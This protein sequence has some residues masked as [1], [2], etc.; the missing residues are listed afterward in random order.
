MVENVSRQDLVR[1]V[2][3][4]TNLFERLVIIKQLLNESRK[5]GHNR[6][7][8]VIEPLWRVKNEG[9]SGRSVNDFGESVSRTGD[10]HKS[11]SLTGSGTGSL[12]ITPYPY[13]V[14]TCGIGVG[15]FSS[16][17][18]A[19]LIKPRNIGCGRRGRLVSSGWACVPRK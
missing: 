9:G 16:A 12:P 18:M 3:R 15:F 13:T 14:V 4:T 19:A 6:S 7:F 10:S 11:K 1:Y 8:P 5:I 2:A 17:C